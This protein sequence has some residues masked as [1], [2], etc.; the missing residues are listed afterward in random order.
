M[1]LYENQ[2]P[3][4]SK[5]VSL[6]CFIITPEEVASDRENAPLRLQRRNELLA[7][8]EAHTYLDRV[9]VFEADEVIYT[10]CERKELW[11]KQHQELLDSLTE[12]YRIPQI[13]SRELDR[14]EHY[15]I[16]L[17]PGD[18]IP[19]GGFT[20]YRNGIEIAEHLQNR[21]HATEL[22]RADAITSLEKIKSQAQEHLKDSTNLL[23]LLQR[24]RAALDDWK[25]FFD[26]TDRNDLAH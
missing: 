16:N 23:A 22:A 1:I 20:L 12:I 4:P 2:Q 24:Q 8:L 10:F 21:E 9:Y 26:H 25:D 17:T 14:Y 6:P 13:T 11:H 5:I 3:F 15:A 18:P 7:Y 19:I